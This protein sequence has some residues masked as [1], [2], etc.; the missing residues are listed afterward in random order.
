MLF[1]INF[2]VYLIYGFSFLV[3]LFCLAFICRY[4]LMSVMSRLS[5]MTIVLGVV[6]EERVGIDVDVWLLVLSP[7]SRAK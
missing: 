6:M 7:Q 2:H 1:Q 5:G 4:C 3:R